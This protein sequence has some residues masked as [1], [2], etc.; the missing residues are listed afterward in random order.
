MEKK[1]SLTSETPACLICGSE[2][3][4]PFLTVPNRFSLSE[5]FTVVKCADCGLVYLSPRPS[6]DEIAVY[7][8]DE[9]YQPHQEQAKTLTER[10]YRFIRIFNNRYK[11]RLIEK[12]V[13]RGKILDYGC[14][15]GEFLVEMRNS[16]WET[17]GFEPSE[18]AAEIAKSYDLNLLTQFADLDQKVDVITLWH[19]LEHIHST[20]DLLEK[21]TIKLAQNGFL[22]LALPNRESYDARSYGRNWV[23]YDAPRHLYHFTPS[24]MENLLKQYNLKILSVHRLMFDAWYNCLL[25][26]QLEYQQAGK[27]HMVTGILKAGVV[28]A[29]S[30]IVSM[31]NARKSSSIIYIAVFINQ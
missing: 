28:A 29:I 20:E 23:A 22:I 31:L 14:G 17:Y 21:I 3:K 24:D 19:V 10:L 1:S 2:S 18:K 15:T 8:K 7:Y 16:K 26:A 4:I 27:R 11:R 5:Q 30:S 25:S 6:E 13:P 12:L 9:N